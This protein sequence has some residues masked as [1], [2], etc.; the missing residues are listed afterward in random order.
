MTIEEQQ[1]LFRRLSHDN[2]NIFRQRQLRL[3]GQILECFGVRADEDTV[4]IF[5]NL[6]LTVMI[7]RRAIPDALPLFVPKAA[8]ETVAFHINSI[9]D[10]LDSI[11]TPGILPE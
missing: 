7:V 5:T 8:N 1:H 9:V 11:R 2:Y 3:F 6:C 4:G 10:W